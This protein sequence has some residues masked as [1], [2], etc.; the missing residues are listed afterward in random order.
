MTTIRVIAAVVDTLQLRLYREDGKTYDIPQGDP[1]LG[2]IL[3][4]I[5][6]ILEA[7][8][9]AIVETGEAPV[10]RDTTYGDYQ[11]KT[12][13]LTRLFRIAKNKLANFLQIQAEEGSSFT[14]HAEP[15]SVGKVPHSEAPSQ[16]GLGLP[17]GVTQSLGIE[18]GGSAPIAEFKLPE[19]DP[20]IDMAKLHAQRA[21]TQLES[22]IKDIMD[23][24][25]PVDDEAFDD[26]DTTKDHTIIAMVDTGSG[27]HKTVVPGVENLKAH[28]QHA[29]TTDNT[30]GMEALLKRLSGIIKDRNH[31]V[32]DILRFISRGDLPLADDGSIIAYKVLKT[33]PG[34]PEGTFVDCHT[35]KVQQRVGSFVTQDPSL[36]SMN[37]A[38]ECG[39]GLHIARRA[40]LRGFSGDI[41]VMVKLAPEDVFVVPKNEPNKVRA[42]GYHILAKIP[43]DEHSSLR[44]NT[45]MSGNNALKL[46]MMA[47]KGDH[48]GIIENV[49]ITS[50]SGGSFRVEKLVAATKQQPQ[51]TKQT[52]KAL[53]VPD[54]IKP[55]ERVLNAPQVNPKEVASKI[56]EGRAKKAVPKVALTKA[57]EARA[58]FVAKK[59]DDLREFKKASKKSWEALKFT[60]DEELFI[61]ETENKLVLA[62]ADLK[63]AKEGKPPVS[64]PKPGTI[65]A[66]DQA[67]QEKAV[68]AI[69]PIAEAVSEA[70]EITI[71]TADLNPA[72]GGKPSISH[73]I[74]KTSKEKPA[75]KNVPNKK[76]KAAIKD[77][78]DDKTVKTGSVLETI[79]ELNKT[80]TR[81][82][83][84]RGY[85]TA[86][87]NGEKSRWGTLW[88]HKKTSKKSWETLGFT[89]KEVDRIVL[90]KPDWI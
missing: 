8:S 81:A 88:Q 89:T 87:V 14:Y 34:L 18:V 28:M 2:P 57:D 30:K 10:V 67:K 58:L 15:I 3:A 79:Q 65:S 48:I 76:T 1:R 83:V 62:L 46:L 44:S 32:D 21:P 25:E 23:H 13:G 85:F 41:I 74:P 33:I 77:A 66:T 64:T 63:A 56:T 31:T 86:A 39:T 35:G 84:A 45:A 49:I 69:A 78:E 4:D 54:V 75:M 61:R 80:G 7:G 40:Y 16:T 70:D 11:K 47:I 36:I 90:N 53:P 60:M 68:S 82:E 27:A 50:A 29:V 37:R 5:I 9:I 55:I 20:G 38:Q 12:S 19:G 71:A 52:P 17:A 22:A 73:T 43:K 51:L 42:R 6:P 26:Q 72:K 24:A 59:W